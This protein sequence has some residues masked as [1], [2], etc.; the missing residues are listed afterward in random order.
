MYNFKY[1][2][3]QKHLFF[4]CVKSLN[5]IIFCY[6]VYIRLCE[7]DNLLLKNCVTNNVLNL[8]TKTKHLI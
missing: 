1:Y 8:F 5:N 3:L 7:Y 6:K 4:D 2:F